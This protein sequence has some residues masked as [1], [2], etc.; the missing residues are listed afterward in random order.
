MQSNTKYLNI[1]MLPFC[2]HIF[3]SSFYNESQPYIVGNDKEFGIWNDALVCSESEQL[4]S[5]ITEKMS[6][7]L[8]ER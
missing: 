5:C 6:S 8:E 4:Y 1:Q 2:G 3:E 7:W